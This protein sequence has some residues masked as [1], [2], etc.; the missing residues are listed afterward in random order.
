MELHIKGLKCDNTTCDYKD[1]TIPFAEYP[2]YID[3]PCPTCGQSL[4]TQ[5]DFDATM[6]L[7]DMMTIVS[8]MALAAQNEGNETSQQNE[9]EPRYR[10][11]VELDG[12]GNPQIDIKK[13]E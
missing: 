13:D 6:Q 1:D 8:S 11:N 9:D 10:I 7:V 5:A 3:H 2:R 4:L 12:T